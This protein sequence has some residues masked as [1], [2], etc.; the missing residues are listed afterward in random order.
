MVLGWPNYI[1]SHLKK[2]EQTTFVMVVFVDGGPPITMKSVLCPTRLSRS[3]FLSFGVHWWPCNCH[4]KDLPPNIH[5]FKPNYILSPFS[6]SF[7]PVLQSSFAMHRAT[8]NVSVDRVSSNLTTVFIFDGRQLGM[9]PEMVKHTVRAAVVAVGSSR[10][11]P[12]L[13]NMVSEKVPILFWGEKD[14]VDKMLRYADP[15]TAGSK[16]VRLFL[17]LR[18]RVPALG[19][20]LKFRELSIAIIGNA[21]SLQPL[22]HSIPLREQIAPIVYPSCFCG[23]NPIKLHMH[24]LH[25]HTRG[26]D[27]ILVWFLHHSP[28]F[29]TVPQLHHGLG[30]DKCGGVEPACGGLVLAASSDS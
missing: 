2:W 27:I 11:P 12:N 4:G 7:V 28:I 30:R 13:N 17:Y 9:P 24:V 20:G 8:D 19:Q 10:E 21:S 26:S 23:C 29:S 6:C 15:D 18:P 1:P 5:G 14:D 22:V 3:H 25:T 16:L